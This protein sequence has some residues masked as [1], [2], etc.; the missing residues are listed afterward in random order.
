[1]GRRSAPKSRAR[2]VLEGTRGEFP[3]KGSY[4]LRVGLVF[5]KAEQ[6]SSYDRGG[7]SKMNPGKKRESERKKPSE[8]SVVEESKTEDRSEKHRNYTKADRGSLIK[9][10]RVLEKRNKRQLHWGATRCSAFVGERGKR[11]R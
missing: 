7:L 1:L 4:V 11:K 3:R 8:N 9:E 10:G 6:K 2:G 5:G